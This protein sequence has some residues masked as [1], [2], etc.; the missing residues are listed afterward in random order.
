MK[1]DPIGKKKQRPKIIKKPVDYRHRSVK[2]INT[3]EL[4]AKINQLV[5]D[6]RAKEALLEQINVKI[7]MLFTKAKNM[8]SEWLN[9][10]LK[11]IDDDDV[12]IQKLIDQI[13]NEPCEEKVALSKIKRKTSKNEIKSDKSVNNFNK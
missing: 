4:D 10:C 11:L 8:G 9:E 2:Y 13:E 12:E 5:Q 6:N 1:K 3:E 7:E